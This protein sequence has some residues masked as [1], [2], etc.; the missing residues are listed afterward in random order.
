MPDAFMFKILF[1]KF[2]V[3]FAVLTFPLTSVRAQTV[4]YNSL[5]R[6]MADRDAVAS[7]PSPGYL[8]KQ[9][10]T[11]NRASVARDQANQT[12]GG[13]FGDGDGGFYIRTE[14]NLLGATEY[15]VMEHNG[16]GAITK[17][18]TP[19]FYYDFNDRRGAK[20][21][22]YLNG[23]TTPVIGEYI[24]ELVT[25]LEWNTAEYGAKPSPSNSFTVPNPVSA[26]TARAGDC[27]LPIPYS[28]SCKVTMSAAPFYDI[29]SYRAYEPGTLVETFSANLYKANSNQAQLVLT[30]QQI[31]TPA[32]FS[33]GN[34]FQTN[35][36]LTPGSA[37]S[38]SLNAGASAVRHLEV[39]LDWNQIA[40]N[41]PPL[42]S[43][44][45]V[46]NFDG[47][48]T[49]WCP[50]GEFF[51][52]SDSLHPFDTFTRSVS[53]NGRMVCRWVMPYQTGGSIT[54]TNLGTN[55]IHA[56]LIARTGAWS[57]NSN[58]MHFHANWRPDDVVA[59]SPPSDWNFIDISGKGVFVGDAW[60]VGNI[61]GGWWG[62]GDEKIYVDDDY[63][64]RKFPGLFGTGTEDYYG[65]AGGVNPTRT[66]EFSTPFLSNVRV[67]GLDGGTLG[68]NIN[69]RHRAL[70]AIPFNYRLKFDMESSFGTDI[71]N[72]W[73][74]LGYS[75]AVFWYA[76][77]GAT[78]NRPPKPADAAKPILSMAQLTG[79]SQAIEFGT[80]TN[81]APGSQWDLGEQDAGAAAGG[82][83]AATTLDTFGN[84]GLAK[85]GSPTY[86]NSVTQGAGALC[87]SFSSGDHYRS[88]NVTTLTGL[89]YNNF[90]FSL[91]VYPTSNPGYN[92]PISLGLYGLRSSFFYI[93]GG[94]WRYNMNGVTD[95][96]LGSAAKMNAWSHL[97][98]RRVAG[99]NKWWINGIQVG[100][101]D[102]TQ[103]PSGGLAPTLNIGG[104]A[105]ASGGNFDTGGDWFGLVDKVLVQNLKPVVAT[106]PSLIPNFGTVLQGGTFSLSI[107]ASGFQPL[108]YM[109]RQNGALVSNTG[110]LPGVTFG[111][112]VPAQTGN[113]DVVITNSYGSVTSSIVAVT[114]VPVN[115]PPAI[116][117]SLSVF[118]NFV[119]VG[120]GFTLT[121]NGVTGGLP[122]TYLWRLNSV[123]V[124]NTG[125]RGSVAF[126][127]VST[128]QSGNYDVVITNAYGTVTS[129]I[130]SV[131][132][133]SGGR[134]PRGVKAWYRLG[135][136][137]PGAAA[138][139]PALTN[140]VDEVG[141]N[142]LGRLGTPVY[143]PDVWTNAGRLSMSFSSATGDW[144]TGTNLPVFNG[145][146]LSNLTVSFDVKPTAAGSF[147]VPVCLGRYGSGC[148]FIYMAGGSWRY[149]I[150]GLGDQIVGGTASLNQW[151]HVS[152]VRTNGVNALFVNG[153]QVGVTGN[154]LFPKVAPDV[155]IGAAKTGA[156]NP[157]GLL[158]GT[159]DNVCITDPTAAE[160]LS[161]PTLGLRVS[162]GRVQVN[163]TGTPGYLHTLWWAPELSPPIWMPVTDRVTSLNGQALLLDS[164][165]L[166]TS[167]FYRVTV[168]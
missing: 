99:V 13:W 64:T 84:N 44:A 68:Y 28:T 6:E 16:P 15:V 73:N 69:A 94:T 166:S 49:V 102:N 75:V 130:V 21:R 154:T 125:S 145:L 80:L 71:R 26:F 1:P 59:G 14:T 117:N 92:A 4:T 53:T 83:G 132:I 11:Y 119:T 160:S 161:A 5:L 19:F 66:D 105:R 109:W 139:N 103:A 12:F 77:P 27:Y 78:D 25:R 168:Q 81:L 23:S 136:A 51:S 36:A 40:T 144:F 32:N 56:T 10:S 108:T 127:N 114:I 29:I 89:D 46:M 123:V 142:H 41:L 45:L 115:T 38:L 158:D 150:N 163:V 120:G 116:S 60:T 3:I 39:Q 149:H 2:L 8:Q 74:V 61:Q 50:L 18:W 62:E 52:S 72:P 65:W 135:E 88:D 97:E 47:E 90:M 159:I 137:D 85:V 148:C 140:T 91:D 124:S 113:Y 147:N 95:I 111:N 164:S 34:L 153:V 151:Q 126:N 22:I 157:D 20:I 30:A 76:V 141:T 110:S 104:I 98:F 138:G 131:T 107:V 67:G 167:A 17:L 79:I 54:L 42:R 101:T 162:G 118:P 134:S 35:N 133:S 106:G 128:Q 146:N 93:S 155:S 31:G 156:G 58:S 87:M 96:S 43:T 9:G 143:S 152:F 82:P 100:P 165:R 86:S 48:Q 37:M 70:D 7:Y 57:W 121:A 63:D 112:A 24:I 33:G 122:L 129:S 55:T